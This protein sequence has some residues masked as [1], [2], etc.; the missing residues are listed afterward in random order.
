M[1]ST[2]TVDDLLADYRPTKPWHYRRATECQLR[3][4]ADL[5]LTPPAGLTRGAASHL[6]KKVWHSLPA[7]ARQ[8]FYL[9]QNGHWEPAL[10]KHEANVLIARL[11]GEDLP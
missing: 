11:K 8:E 7:T 2:M 10:S 1:P 4:L 6:I 3:Y 9:Q 5:G